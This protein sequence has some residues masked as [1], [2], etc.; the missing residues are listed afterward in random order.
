MFKLG[1]SLSQEAHDQIAEVI[2]RHMDAFAWSASNMPDIDPD[3]LC[4]HC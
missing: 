2:A 3:F 1:K 4:H